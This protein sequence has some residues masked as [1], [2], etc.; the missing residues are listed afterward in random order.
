MREAR[1]HGLAPGPTRAR[2]LAGAR[3]HEFLSGPA[4]LCAG[5]GI[6]RT[7]DGVDLCDARASL[8]IA[9]GR[10]AARVRWTPRIGLNPR[11]ASF[12]WGWRA[13]ALDSRAV[14]SPRSAARSRGRPWPA[15]RPSPPRAMETA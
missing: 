12:E 6:D 5:L 7:L 1:L 10:R 11:S 4:R 8:W 15:R 13:L 14:S 9:A 3:E 2:L